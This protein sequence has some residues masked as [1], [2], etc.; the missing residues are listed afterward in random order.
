MTLRLKFYGAKILCLLTTVY[1]ASP[2]ITSLKELQISSSKVTDYGVTFLKG[3][4]F[5]LP[6]FL[7]K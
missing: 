7:H 4:C 1:I 5:D 6:V 3:T 2:G